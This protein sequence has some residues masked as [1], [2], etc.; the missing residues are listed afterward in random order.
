MHV[1]KN[2][3]NEQHVM[4]IQPYIKWGPRK[5][6][7]SPELKIQEAEAL[8]RS[9]PRWAI[10]D[11]IKVPLESLDKRTLFGKGKL[12]EMRQTINKIRG[13]GGKVYIIMS[14]L[15]FI[16]F[17]IDARYFTFSQIS[18][19]FVSKGT[20]TG[21]QKRNLEQCFGLPVMDRY[22]VVIQILRLHATSNEAK[23]QVAMAELPY[24]WSQM[25][26]TSESTTTTGGTFHSLNDTQ[27]QL[28]RNREKKL[29]TEL[30]NIRTH[31]YIVFQ[32]KKNK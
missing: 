19:V 12:E 6:V 8:V 17:I 11:S 21:S 29:K 22:S 4:V 28:L 24:I 7:T 25:K 9:L 3:L 14:C 5:S 26:D 2:I 10:V 16:L 31:R 15:E 32:L 13:S 18:C 23:L 20:I 30:N 27:K 1:T